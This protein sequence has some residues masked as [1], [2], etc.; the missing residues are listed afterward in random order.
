MALGWFGEATGGPLVSSL[1]LSAAR[2]G[3]W[4]LQRKEPEGL[5]E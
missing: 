1:D 3:P 4:V 2:P 5:C